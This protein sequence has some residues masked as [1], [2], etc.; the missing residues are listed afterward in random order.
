LRKL[1]NFAEIDVGGSAGSVVRQVAF[2]FSGQYLGVAVGSEMKYVPFYL[3]FLALYYV[4]C[5]SFFLY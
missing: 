1:T 2:D 4:V 5:R 3:F